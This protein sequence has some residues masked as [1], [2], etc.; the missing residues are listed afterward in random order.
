MKMEKHI[1]E[2]LLDRLIEKF[3]CTSKTETLEISDGN[4]KN[5]YEPQPLSTHL[6]VVASYYRYSTFS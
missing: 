5:R 6:I 4:G 2:D 1:V 3:A